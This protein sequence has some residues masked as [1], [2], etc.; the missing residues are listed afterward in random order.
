M[1]KG[2]CATRIEIY[3]RLDHNS[4]KSVSIRTVTGAD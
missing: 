4:L 1:E 3:M 2:I